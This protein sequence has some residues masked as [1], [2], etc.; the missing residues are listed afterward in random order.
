MNK[1]VEK[2]D[3]KK[4]EMLRN[5]IATPDQDMVAKLMARKRTER[6]HEEST[7][8][9]NLQETSVDKEGSCGS[10]SSINTVKNAPIKGSQLL[11]R[12]QSTGA[13]M[14]EYIGDKTP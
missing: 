11:S 3:R 9:E 10:G 4:L 7:R 6:Q 5:F 8:I 12:D 14:Y 1:V 2:L 13:N